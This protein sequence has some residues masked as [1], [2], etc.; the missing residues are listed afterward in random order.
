MK[1][2]HERGFLVLDKKCRKSKVLK[3]KEE[4]IIDE[5]IK[6][7]KKFE[8]IRAIRGKKSPN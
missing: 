8:L 3:S 6:D 5:E 1:P 2:R 4:E 7:L